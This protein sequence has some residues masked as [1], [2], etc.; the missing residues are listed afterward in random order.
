MNLPL[1]PAALLSAFASAFTQNKRLLKLAFSPGAGIADGLLLPWTLTGSEAINVGYRYELACLSP[2]AYLPLK[3]LTGQPVEVSIL[4][5]TGDYRPLSGWVTEA[6]QDGADG[7]LSRY[8]L[9]IEDLFA[10][11]KLRTNNRIFQETSSK[12]AVLNIVREHRQGNAI[13]AGSLDIDDRTRRDYPTQALISQLDESDA[14]F[15]K[16]KLADEGISF[17]FEYGD[18]GQCGDRPKVTL[19]L[20]DDNSQLP[21]NPAGAVRYHRAD[22]TEDT[23]SITAWHNER[24]LVPG[25]VYRASPD[26]KPLNID[27]QQEQSRLDQGEAGNALSASLED[28]RYETP[29]YGKT[30]EDYAR[31][32]E[33]RMQA[34]EFAGKQ[35]S[36]AGTVRAFTLGRFRLADHPEIDQHD[37]IDREFILTQITHHARNNLPPEVKDQAKHLTPDARPLTPDA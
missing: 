32:T 27:R 21:D 10:L 31:Y 5:D 13:L 2:D 11:L 29:H 14:G 24:T 30:S 36:G 4:T 37:A 12:D 34:H 6:R 25:A 28:Y 33:L 18:A 19:V 17:Y 3:D 23:D 1:D 20:F 26:Y 22:G 7:G 9:V 15:C 8:T 35:F 16:R